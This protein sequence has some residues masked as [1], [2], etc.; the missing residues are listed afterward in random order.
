LPA[1][2]NQS[3]LV[4]PSTAF[5]VL[6]LDTKEA[7]GQEILKTLEEGKYGDMTFL[8]FC[9]FKPNRSI[10][11]SK[12]MLFILEGEIAPFLSVLWS[13]EFSSIQDIE[14]ENEKNSI[15]LTI[16]NSNSA[17]A[18]IKTID[19]HEVPK[20]LPKIY[21]VILSVL[22]PLEETTIVNY[23]K[24]FIA[25]DVTRPVSRRI[26]SERQTQ[27][28][29]P[30][31]NNRVVEDLESAETPSE[32]PQVQEEQ[33]EEAQLVPENDESIDNE[34]PEI[35]NLN[36]QPLDVEMTLIVS[37]PAVENNSQPKN[38]EEPCCPCLIL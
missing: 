27:E 36:E 1:P 15:R 8:F 20:F 32:I 24:N 3:C 12:A 26:K 10:L 21:N 4:L 7:K 22:K 6:A 38:V 17:E 34:Q 37:E 11:M 5:E 16:V 19:L 28:N 33:E 25:P 30:E 13:T 9:F 35:T 29:I 2:P 14:M 18:I 31:E 23:Q